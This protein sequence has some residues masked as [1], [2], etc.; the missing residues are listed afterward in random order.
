MSKKTKAKAAS[1]IAR[2]APITWSRGRAW[3]DGD[4]VRMDRLDAE[5]YE[6][7]RV[8]G[9]LLP[10]ITRVRSAEDVVAF[11]QRFGLLSGMDDHEKWKWYTSTAEH[12][13]TIVRLHRAIAAASDGDETARQHIWS[14]AEQQ[15]SVFELLAKEQQ[16]DE[17][18]VIRAITRQ[19]MRATTL[20][21]VPL[22]KAS[23]AEL[24][25]KIDALLS[26][27]ASVIDSRNLPAMLLEA[28]A[29]IAGEF[30]EK[31]FGAMPYVYDR[32]A[33]GEAVRPGILRIGVRPLSLVQVCYLVLALALAEKEPLD[34]CPECER[35]FVIEDRRQKFCSPGCANRARFRRFQTKKAKSDGKKARKV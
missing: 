32:S 14:W 15:R 4:Y 35:V 27:L 33:A 13:R 24:E 1:V 16:F 20:L 11:V 31:L 29:W 6:P 21:D 8:Q 2:P 23:L 7:F 9:E 10:A 19:K 18:E 30:T 26:R 5:R 17:A 12:L 34:V 22:K 28:G 3:L 25:T